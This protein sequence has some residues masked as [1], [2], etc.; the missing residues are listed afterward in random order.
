MMLN[1][2]KALTE[3]SVILSFLDEDYKSKIPNKF[4]NFIENEK[5]KNYT[6]NINPKIPLEEQN[7]LQDTINI[8]ALLKLDYLCVDEIEKQELIDLLKQNEEDYQ[9]ML[10]KKYNPNNLFRNCRQED[11]NEI[12][13]IAM[14][15]YKESIFK[16]ILNK[17][18]KLFKK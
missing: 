12:P 15:E 17:I 1:L 13:Y 11:T 9:Q 6:P 3:V 14:V 7:L 2:N 8:L 18:K 4:I 16:I 10:R 5:D